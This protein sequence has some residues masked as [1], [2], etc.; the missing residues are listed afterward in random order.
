M[1]TGAGLLVLGYYV[2][3]EVGKNDHIKGELEEKRNRENGDEEQND[4]ETESGKP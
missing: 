3:R 4:T 2:G 1:L